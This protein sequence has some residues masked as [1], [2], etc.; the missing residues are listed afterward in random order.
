MKVYGDVI[1]NTPGFRLRPTGPSP[2]P[3]RR[4]TGALMIGADW[5]FPAYYPFGRSAVS[6]LKIVAPQLEWDISTQRHLSALRVAHQRWT[7]AKRAFYEGGPD[8]DLDLDFPSDFTPYKHQRLGIAMSSLWWRAFF[9]WEMG[10]GKTRTVIDGF[11]FSRRE[12]PDL[13]RM[14]V[15]APPVVIPTWVDEVARCSQGALR[16]VVVTGSD[17]S[18]ADAQTA[19]VVVASYA[20]A[21]LEMAPDAPKRFL[22][23]NFQQIVGDE[24]HS[25][26]SA[27]SE[28]TKAVLQLSTLAPRRYLL[29]GTAADHPGKLYPQFRFLSSQ[30]LDMTW[31]KYQEQYFSRSKFRKGQ[32]FS[33]RHLDDLNARV[34]AIASRMK[35]RDCIDLPPVTFVDIGYDLTSA[36]IDAYDACIARLR[37]RELYQR[38]LSGKGVAIVHGAALVNKLLQVLSGFM[39]EGPDPSVCDGCAH[40]LGCVTA[41]IRPYTPDCQVVKLRPKST[42][43]RIASQKPEMFRNLLRTILESDATNKV[44]VWG[45][46]MEELNAMEAILK[47]EGV[48]YV[49]V[50]GGSTSKIGPLAKAFQSDPDCRVY[51]GQIRSGVGVTLTAANYMIY[52]S[53]TWDLKDYKQSLERNNR[54]G[55]KRDMTV[56]RLLSNRE[57]ALDRFLARVLTFKD[58][59]AYTM[60]ERVTC[61]SCPQQTLCAKAEVRPFKKGCKYEANVDRPQARADYLGARYIDATDFGDDGSTEGFDAVFADVGDSSS[62]PAD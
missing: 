17:S 6:D 30:L 7:I 62:E 5:W 38:L 56:Y 28:Q 58:Q 3:W 2:E 36:Q 37:D 45:T 18:W 44:I 27:E 39:I 9:L 15:L 35:K 41:N 32:V 50:D 54:P 21:R 34:D 22:T 4:V 12:N 16:A 43:Q 26:G 11:R 59:V 31:E 25:I 51:L 23:L 1:N 60:L 8:L 42:I 52:Y 57:G 33:Y 47:N 48:G 40:L 19:D 53:L 10:T 13:K 14:L 61:S 29:S 55:Q 46:Y 49:R 24:S 20:R